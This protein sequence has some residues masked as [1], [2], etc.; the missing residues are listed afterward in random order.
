MK[1][2]YSIGEYEKSVSLV[3]AAVPEAA[4][5]TDV[6]AGFPGET[7]TEFEESLEFCRRMK[8]ARIHV[9]PYSPRSGTLAARM[10][11]PVPDAVKR[12]RTERMLALAEESARVFARQF[13]GSL[14]PI[15]W[16]KK[17]GGLWSG[18]TDNYMKVYTRSSEDLTNR[19]IPVKIGELYWDGVWG[20]IAG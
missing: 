13:D 15:L 4:V 17:S 18:L 19:L 6:I 16:E 1:R 12:Q 5:T 8:F 9:F 3:R 7:E 11:N 14:M 20:G 2:R 10:P